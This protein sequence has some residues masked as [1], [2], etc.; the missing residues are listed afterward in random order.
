M[1]VVADSSAIV[2][3][4]VLEV[5]HEVV[6]GVAEPLTVSAL[7]V[8]EV[9][10]A[11]WFKCRMGHLTSAQAAVLCAQFSTD[12][13]RSALSAEHDLPP[14]E[15]PHFIVVEC[16][17]DVIS[18]ATRMAA[19][20]GLRAG[21]AVHLATAMA[22]KSAVNDATTLLTFDKDLADAARTEGLRVLP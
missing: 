18:G 4:Y 2:K 9:Q 12:L 10:S 3:L 17:G 19:R 16:F 22:V 20:H 6:H 8:V 11:F 1:T 7:A 15:L 21:D 5:G 14:T 13:D